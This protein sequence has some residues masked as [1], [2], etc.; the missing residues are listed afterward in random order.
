[1]LEL[2]LNKP[3]SALGKWMDRRGIKQEWLTKESGLS[4][5]T[6]SA[7]CNEDGHIPNGRTMQKIVQALR[8]VDPSV[9]ASQFWDID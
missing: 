4:K 9:K 5:K 6:V 7:V 3:R 8:T 2:G 1:M